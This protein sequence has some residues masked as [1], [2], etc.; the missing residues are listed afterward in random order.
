MV[1]RIE[2]EFVGGSADGHPD[3]ASDGWTGY[4][5][6]EI[7]RNKEAAEHQE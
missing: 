2:G 7:V 5:A 6:V 3:G 4:F 1:F